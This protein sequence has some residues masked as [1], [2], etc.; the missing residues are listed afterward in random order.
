MALI[1][2]PEC[3]KEVS[4]RSKICIGCG[5]PIDEYVKEL[6]EAKKAAE[7]EAKLYIPTCRSCGS[8][9]IDQDGY[10]NECGMKMVQSTVKIEPIPEPE[11]DQPHRICPSCGRRNE[12]DTFTCV[13][14]GHKYTPDQYIECYVAGKGSYE[15]V[16][17]RCGSNN[18]HAFVE[19]E[20][21]R[22]GKVKSTTSWNLNPLKPFTV[23]N[24]KEKVV[25]KPLTRKVSK[26][27]CDDCGKIF[28]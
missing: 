8:Q 5:F 21:I 27:I 3:G 24:H 11:V 13:G 9:D 16:C 12:L 19:E 20:V 17:P 26:L 1:K 15:V 10:C 18:H 25:R 28:Q 4:D 2:C 14:F 7:E 23:F 22:K 6:E